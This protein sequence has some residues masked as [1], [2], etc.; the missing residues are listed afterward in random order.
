MVKLRHEENI[1]KCRFFEVPGDGSALLGM[2]HIEL[3][4]I[5]KT[6]YEVVGQQAGIQLPD[7]G[8]HPVF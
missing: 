6:M 7:S 5:L 8:T 2:P 4:G 1:A 3:L